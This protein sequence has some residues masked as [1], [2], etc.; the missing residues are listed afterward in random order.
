MTHGPHAAPKLKEVVSG[1]D[2][3]AAGTH[4]EE[5]QHWDPAEE[6]RELTA[7]DPRETVSLGE[8]DNADRV[9]LAFSRY[10]SDLWHPWAEREK[11]VRETISLY[12]RLFTLKQQFEEG[13]V[14]QALE[15]VWGVGVGIWDSSGSKVSYPLITR[16]VEPTCMKEPA[17]SRFARGHSHAWSSIGTHLLTILAWLRSRKPAR[18]SSSK[19]R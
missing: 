4:R 18:S 1:R 10:E 6:Q 8:Y 13:I 7:I 19:R 17:L 5:G 11:A 16:L 3:I 14:E 2:L 9:R 15:L 12:S